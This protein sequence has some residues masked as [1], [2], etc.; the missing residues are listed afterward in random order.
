YNGM[1]ILASNLKSHLDNAFMRRF[2]S[3]VHFPKPDKEDRK[4]IWEK[5]I[6]ADLP[7]EASMDIR[8]LSDNYEVT[9]AQISNVVQ[10]C[11]IDAIAAG[12]ETINK[13]MLRKNLRSE[14]QK[15]DL[16]F[17]DYLA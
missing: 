1:V 5:T 12:S 11:F 2:Q 7:L 8:R 17:E 6:P 16:L 3:V 4:K 14:L 13:S 9:A 10:A 15:E